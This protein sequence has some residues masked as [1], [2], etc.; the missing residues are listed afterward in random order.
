MVGR[1]LLQHAVPITFGVKVAGWLDPQAE[2]E[3][4]HTGILGSEFSVIEGGHL[5][6]V[7]NPSAFND[8]VLKFLVE[9]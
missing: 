9:T 1:T 4:L 3:R 7:D 5:C 2:V 6:N 8:A